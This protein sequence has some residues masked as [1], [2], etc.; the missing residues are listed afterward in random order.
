MAQIIKRFTGGYVLENENQ[1]RTFVKFVRKD[2]HFMRKSRS[3]G[4]SVGIVS[5]LNSMDVRA[6][7]LHI[8]DE[9]QV[10]CVDMETFNRKSIIERYNGYEEQA[11]LHEA[12]WAVLG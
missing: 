1:Y 6:I 2:L 3:W 7:E 5:D 12:F 4:I 10:V 8:T 11:F 9:Q